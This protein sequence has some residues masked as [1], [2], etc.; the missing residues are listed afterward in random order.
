MRIKP[1]TRA[2]VDSNELQRVMTAALHAM[3]KDYKDCQFSG[4]TK[5]Q[6]PDESGC[7]WSEPKIRCRGIPGAVCKAAAAIVTKD[8]KAKCNIK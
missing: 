4:M 3:E 7:N 8:F 1:I 2:I 6:K 5:L